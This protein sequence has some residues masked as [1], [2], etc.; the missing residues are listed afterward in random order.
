MPDNNVLNGLQNGTTWQDVM[1]AVYN[2]MSGEFQ[3]RI[4]GLFDT[5]ADLSAFGKALMEYKPGANEFLYS[6]INHIGLVNVNY[7]NFESPLKM[8]KKGWMEFG[9]TIEDVYIEPIKGMLYEEEV[10]NDNP[11]DV[12]QT[13]KPDQDVVFYKINRECVYPLTINERVI[14]RAFMSYRELDKFMSGLMRQ[15]QN[16]DELD[17]FSL[18]MKLLEN[19]SDVNGQNLYYQI[20]VDEVTDETSAKTLV[21]AVRSVV[22]GLRFPTR[23]YNA[24]GVLNWARP[25]DMYL[26]VTPE[27]NSI[28][29][30]D[31]LAKAFN[32]DKT[33]FMGN[34]VEVPGFAGDNMANVQA[35][36]IDKE[37]IQDYDT[38]RD[39]LS[40]GVNARHLTTN[41]YYHHQGIMACSP[42]YH[43]IAFTSDTFAD[44]T[45]VTITGP[46]RVTKGSKEAVTYTAV[47]SAG[48]NEKVQSQAVVWEIE[49]APQYASINQNGNLVIGNK[50]AG[51]TLKIKATSVLKDTVYAEK[52]ITVA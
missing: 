21:K 42:F 23:S 39:I 41:Y 52:T 14:R 15:L 49:G 45:T 28:L 33:E 24:K 47:V 29:D 17:D 26:L 10:P 19:Y 5:D 7:R 25:E 34:V 40:T 18:T 11:G 20:P 27:I 3:N 30:V 32:M 50:F 36:L 46:N 6:L 31:V 44:P 51:E 37:F 12:W 35:L 13:F 2:D 9:D 38:Y 48:E 8:F 1:K 16:G 4:E 22:K 43:A